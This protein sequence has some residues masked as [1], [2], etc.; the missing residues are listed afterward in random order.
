MG[1]KEKTSH[2]RHGESFW[3]E[4]KGG[5]GYRMMQRMGWERG[6]GLGRERQGTTEFV[7]AKRKRDGAGL[8]A[9]KNKA[10]ETWVAATGMFNDLL[11]RLNAAAGEGGAG[12]VR[13]PADEEVGQEEREDRRST[14]ARMESY[15]A[16]RRLYSKFRKA[17]NAGNARNMN[18]IFGRREG[19]KDAGG[20]AA[21]D[22]DADAD[23]AE[24]DAGGVAQVIVTSSSSIGDYFQRKMSAPTA[25]P[26]T[27]FQS[28][29]GAGFSLTQQEDY[30][31][32]MVGMSAS[33]RAGLGFGGGGGGGGSGGK[34]RRKHGDGDDSD[35]AEASGSSTAGA[36]GEDAKGD[37]A[38]ADR[39][40]RKRQKREKKEKKRARKEQKRRKKEKREKAKR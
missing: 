16:G 33:G 39:R 10:N 26:V 20:K 8:G 21:D 40:E 7:R 24:D 9:D 34:R 1:R 29:S 35:D 19:D 4:E 18:E 32:A 27:E 14:K 13:N 11:K 30:Y 12:L 28:A 2:G 22:A 5:F 36:D 23:A 17:K 6:S 38:D 15:M 25:K 3:E 37:D 31:A